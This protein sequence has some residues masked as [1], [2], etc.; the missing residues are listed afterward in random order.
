MKTVAKNQKVRLTRCGPDDAL[1]KPVEALDQPF[2]QVLRAA[3]DLSHL[4]CRRPREHDQGTCAT[5]H[6]TTIE[7]VI[8]NP[9]GRPISTALSGRG[10]ISATVNS[11]DRAAPVHA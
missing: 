1:E 3:R 8:G 2:H 5:I 10:V 9:N 4:P 7:F 11:T 6:V